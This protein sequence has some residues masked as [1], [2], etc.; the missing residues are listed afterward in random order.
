[1]F[2][3]VLVGVDFS[4]ASRR[5]LER[6]AALARELKLPLVAV[7]VVENAKPPFYAA[8]APLGDP[9]WFREVEP[10]AHQ[11]LAEWLAPYP[12]ARAIVASGSPGESLMAEADPDTLLV[13]GQV[14]HNALEHL[15]FGSTANRV[16]HHAVCDVLVVR[17]PAER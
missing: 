11:K 10:M 14:G 3:R 2:N 5:A 4:P 6:G 1:M 15:L 12:S 8:Y 16:V 9:G 13:V 17:E 7:H